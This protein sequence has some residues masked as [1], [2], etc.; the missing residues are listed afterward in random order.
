MLSK[1]GMVLIAF[2]KFTTLPERK[3]G[4]QNIKANKFEAGLMRFVDRTL[5]RSFGAFKNEFD[6]GQAAKKRAVIQLINV[7]MGGQKRMYHRWLGI[8]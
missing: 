4:K 5:A 3:D 1:A 7:T 2:K 8:T 6:L